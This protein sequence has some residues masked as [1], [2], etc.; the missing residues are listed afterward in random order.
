MINGHS[1]VRLTELL[2]KMTEIDRRNMKIIKS[3]RAFV[4]IDGAGMVSTFSQQTV[5]TV[6]LLKKGKCE[7]ESNEWISLFLL[8]FKNAGAEK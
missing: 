7:Y 3:F 8:E 6:F 4:T 2:W 1:A 5:I